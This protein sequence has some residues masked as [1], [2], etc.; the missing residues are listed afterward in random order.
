L[1]GHATLAAAFVLFY[2]ENYKQDKIQ[3]YSPRSGELTIT[4][5]GEL[6]TLN[7]PKDTIEE[8]EIFDALNHCF[9]IKPSL[10]Y[11]GKTDYLLLFKNEDEI[12]KLIPKV[13][14]ISQLPA[15]GVIVSA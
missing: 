1:C 10:A 8:V 3:F 14:V 11:K 6:L 12:K 15:H 2:H 5:N 9:N 13:N 4:K 7:F